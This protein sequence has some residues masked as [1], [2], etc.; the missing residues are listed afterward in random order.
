MNEDIETHAP[1][2]Q[3]MNNCLFPVAL[4]RRRAAALRTAKPLA[5]V[6]PVSR[7]GIVRAVTV[8]NAPVLSNIGRGLSAVGVAVVLVAGLVAP[9]LA[10]A[11]G[12]EPR[13]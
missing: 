9:A 1:K 11:A 6:W 5:A 10:G 4:S 3:R 2:N 8:F 7:S 12:N 13:N